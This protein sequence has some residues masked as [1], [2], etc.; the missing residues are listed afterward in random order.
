MIK[1]IHFSLSVYSFSG[2]FG[3]IIVQNT[4]QSLIFIQKIL[5]S[6]AA[7]QKVY[8]FL[9]LCTLDRFGPLV[10]NGPLWI[11]CPHWTS[12]DHLST[13]TILDYF[14]LP[15]HIGQY[16]ITLNHWSTL[17]HFGPYWTT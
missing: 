10:H 11:T 5:G 2:V 12:L 6:Y 8:N 3:K 4:L 14:E 1:N 16:W 15:V 9:H 7:S 13:W 17:D